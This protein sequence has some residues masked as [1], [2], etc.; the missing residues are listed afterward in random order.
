M[1]L[2]VLIRLGRFRC[3]V[4]FGNMNLVLLMKFLIQFCIVILLKIMLLVMQFSKVVF[5]V[6][7]IGNFFISL[8]IRVLF[9]MMMGMLIMMLNIISS[10]WCFLVVCLVVLVM[11]IMLFRF[12]IRFVMIM[13]L[14]VFY[15]WL[16]LLMLVC[17][18]FLLSS[19]M[20]IFSNRMLLISLRNG[21]C[22]IVMVKVIR[23]MWM[24]IVFIVFQ[25]MFF[26]CSLLG[27][28]WQVRVIMMVLLLLSRI[29][30]RMI[31]VMVIQ[32]RLVRNFMYVFL[33]KQCFG[34]GVWLEDC[35]VCGQCFLLG[36]FVRN[37]MG[38]WSFLCWFCGIVLLLWLSEL[39]CG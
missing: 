18:L 2:S 5:R 1:I 29:L 23:V 31:C 28:L 12:I 20:L 37:D 7:M 26:M 35:V 15:R 13:V 3:I 14:M 34:L 22:S 8:S 6:M 27:R 17:L 32:F 9:Q 11:V 19:L 21:N 30:I 24:L 4:V 36:W 25:M 38:S 16:L 10:S 33:E 39:V